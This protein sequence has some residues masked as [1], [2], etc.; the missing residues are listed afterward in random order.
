MKYWKL[1]EFDYFVQYQRD[2]VSSARKIRNTCPTCENDGCQLQCTRCKSVYYCNK[3]CQLAHWPK[4]KKIC[5]IFN[6]VL[7]EGLKMKES[8]HDFWHGGAVEVL[9]ILLLMADIEAELT[10]PLIFCP[11]L[12]GSEGP[13]SMIYMTVIAEGRLYDIYS[14]SHNRFKDPNQ[15]KFSKDIYP[16]PQDLS[17]EMKTLLERYQGDMIGAPINLPDR[18]TMDYDDKRLLIKHGTRHRIEKHYLSYGDRDC[19]IRLYGE[20]II[21]ETNGETVEEFRKR[22]DALIARH[23]SKIEAGEE[24]KRIAFTRWHTHLLP[25]LK[26]ET[27]DRL[28]PLKQRPEDLPT[29][30][31]RRRLE[32]MSS[33]MNS[34][35]GTIFLVVPDG[36]N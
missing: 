22:M 20:K 7:K 14:L 31:P 24:N 15:R 12:E 1:H 2:L 27:F 17:D 10:L 33:M 34:P 26:K 21:K 3:S 8:F 36:S 5:N 13:M 25:A 30:V 4:H 16:L 18:A 19:V 35:P 6:H 23:P 11:E 9:C 28:D 29:T 32:A